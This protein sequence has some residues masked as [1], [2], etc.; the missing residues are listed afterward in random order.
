MLFDAYDD[1]AERMVHALRAE[2]LRTE[3]NEPYSGKI[4]LIYSANRHGTQHDVPYLELEIRQDLIA[5]ERSARRV[6]QRVFHALTAVGVE[7]P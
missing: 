6:A 5:A 1:V 7:A 3:A 2:G 4:G